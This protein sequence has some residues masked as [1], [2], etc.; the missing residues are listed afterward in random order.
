MTVVLEAQKVKSLAKLPFGASVE[1]VMEHF[2]RDGG[3][4]LEGALSPEQVGQVNRELD[5]YIVD[6]HTGS[7]G[8]DE[9]MKEFWGALTKRVTNV[10]TLSEGYRK[11]FLENPRIWDYVSA[12]FK[13]VSDSFWVQAT[14]AIE[15]MPGEDEQMLH[16]DMGNY[17]VF[18]RYGPD[19]PEVTCNMIMALVD[20]TEASGATRIIP[21]SHRWD[22]ERECTQ[23]MTIPAE[24]QAGSILFYSGKL[25][26][27]GGANVTKDVRR[28]VI[29]TAFNPGFLVPEEAYPFTVPMDIVRTMPPRLQQALGFRSFHQRD[30]IG[31]SLWQHNYEELAGYLGL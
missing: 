13:G 14:Q 24:M 16:R 7:L 29:S 17:P 2:H 23:D 20:V 11:N 8:G 31:G 18:Y 6:Y 10:V 28:R 9:L 5:P 4:V 27:G 25:V 22:F 26:H 19:G 3:L 15:I 30:P 12:V 1:E 21:G